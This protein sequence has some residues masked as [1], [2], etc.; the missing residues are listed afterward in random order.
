MIGG[1]GLVD[2]LDRTA[3]VAFAE[4]DQPIILIGN[5]TGWLGASAYLAQIEGRAEG[6]P[7]PVDLEA[8]RANGD[9][10]RE[11]INASDV[12]ACH[13]ISDGGLIVAIAEMAMAGGMGARLK[14]PKA[15]IPLF[16]WLYGEDQAR[17]VLTVEDS[18]GLIV[19]ARAAGVAAMVIGRTGG[20]S[21]TVDSAY[22]ISVKE[23]RAAHESWMPAYMAAS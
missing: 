10:V 21:L 12:T 13:D 23:L 9:F 16:A 18:S 20:E 5:S 8:E 19:K 11:R 3:R 6:A 22:T 17:Y 15:D 1:L 14:S 4:P 7:P 2:D